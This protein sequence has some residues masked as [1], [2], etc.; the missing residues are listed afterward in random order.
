MLDFEVT[1]KITK[2]FLLSKFSQETIFCH[3]LGISNISKKLIRNA[4]RNDKNPTCG[5][6]KNRTGTLILH[7]FATGEYFNC[8]SYVMKSYNCSYHEA[9]DII[10]S[11]F[12]LIKHKDKPVQVIREVPEFKDNDKITYIQV[13]LGSYTE[14]DLKWW[15]SFGIT[16]KTLN[17]FRVFPCNSIFLNGNLVSRRAQHNPIYGYYFGKKDGVEQWRIYFPQRKEMKFM[18]NVPTKTIQGYK[19]LPKTGKLLVITKSMKDTMCLYELGIPSCSPNSET[20]FVADNVLDDLRQRFKHIIVLYDLDA[21][22]I[23]FSKKI[24]Q[25]YPW[26]TVTLL[27]RGKHCKDISDFYKKYGKRETKL[28][29]NNKLKLYK[30]CLNRENIIQQ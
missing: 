12:G 14:Q 30:Q 4:T 10:A 25:K 15:G 20:Q 7:D 28:M 9:L 13:E 27:P 16:E 6:Y 23:A 17:K 5:F 26:L 19:Q 29:I 2:D 21:T 8:F 22:G 24:K 11:D 3:Y 1:P 18:G